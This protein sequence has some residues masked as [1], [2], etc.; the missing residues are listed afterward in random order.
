MGAFVTSEILV[1]PTPMR[2]HL[3]PLPILGKVPVFPRGRLSP[4]ALRRSRRR[5]L[6]NL[7]VGLPSTGFKNC[8][9]VSSKMSGTRR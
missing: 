4:M 3:Q 2:K 1:N 5:L 8:K 6:T 7:C 9:R